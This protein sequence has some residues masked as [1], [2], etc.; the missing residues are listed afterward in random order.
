MAHPKTRRRH[1]RSTREPLIQESANSSQSL[2][3]GYVVGPVDQC[4]SIFI[5]GIDPC[6]FCFISTSEIDMRETIAL[7]S[8]SIQCEAKPRDGR[9][10][11]SLLQQVCSDIVVGI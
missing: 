9:I 6:V 1:I 10:N 5:A 4:F 3:G 2:P 8:G 11:L 7:V